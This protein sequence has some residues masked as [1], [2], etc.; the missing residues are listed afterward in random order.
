[1]DTAGLEAR[2]ESVAESTG[3][4]RVND[5]DSEGMIAGR[6]R[7]ANSVVFDGDTFG[8]SFDAESAGV[9]GAD[10]GGPPTST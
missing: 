2:T 4:G 7:G 10:A 3:E 8:I 9:F 6:A 1:L 5:V